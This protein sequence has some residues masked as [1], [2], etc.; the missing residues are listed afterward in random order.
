MFEPQLPFLVVVA[1]E[2]QQAY[3]RAAEQWRLHHGERQPTTRHRPV[4]SVLAQVLIRFRHWLVE[5]GKPALPVAEV[6]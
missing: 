2:R 3:V 4:R 6:W 1:R 5:S